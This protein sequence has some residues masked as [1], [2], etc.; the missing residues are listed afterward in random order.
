[1]TA[2]FFQRVFSSLGRSDIEM[3]LT[4]QTLTQDPQPVQRSWVMKISFGMVISPFA[5]CGVEA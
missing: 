4:G 1:M 2:S 3:Q 5:F